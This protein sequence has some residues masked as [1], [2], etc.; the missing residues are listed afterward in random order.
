VTVL[1]SVNYR[2]G[3]PKPVLATE[4][5][6]D[7]VLDDVQQ[8]STEFGYGVIAT[9][10]AITGPKRFIDVGANG[11]RGFV[12]RGSAD[13]ENNLSS[14][15]G[16]DID[17]CVWYAFQD[18]HDHVPAAAEIP[19]ADVRASA[20]EFMTTGAYPTVVTWRSFPRDC[21]HV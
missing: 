12:S 19:Y 9:L 15:G 20:H 3:Q 4:A 13:G 14:Y 11:D 1:I 16:A 6:L 18:H 21:G 17:G 5:E 7:A 2:C 8:M 10:S